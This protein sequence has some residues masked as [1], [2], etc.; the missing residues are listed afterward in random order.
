MSTYNNT[1]VGHT[2]SGLAVL[3]SEITY[4][5]LAYIIMII[6]ISTIGNTLIL[7][8]IYNVTSLQSISSLLVANLALTDLCMSL[9]RLPMVGV[10]TVN[11]G[12]KLGP[13]LCTTMGLIDGILTKE[14]IM[15]LLC[16]GINR[17]VAVHRPTFY[18]SAKNKRFCKWCVISGWLYSLAWS[19]PPL[20]G[21]GAYSYIEN[22]MFCGLA[23]NTK[24]VFEAIHITATAI[25]PALVGL[26]LYSSVLCGVF[27]HV[28]KVN[29]NMEN[30][31]IEMKEIR[32][33]TD[34]A[35]NVVR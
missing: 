17:F 28:R 11:H 3:S 10:T 34:A 18:S 27:R 5:V 14:Q 33:N 22:T 15:A 19:L 29:N 24:S 12:W 9:L 31:D 21:L 7:Y 20:F 35:N 23:W 2:S 4:S 26:F 6:L 13:E 25:L 8:I 30:K 1:S 32:P 16:I